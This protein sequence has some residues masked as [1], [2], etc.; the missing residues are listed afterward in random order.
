VRWGVF[1]RASGLGGP[2]RLPEVDTWRG[3]SRPAVGRV[4]GGGSR[5]DSRLRRWRNQVPPTWRIDTRR[6][7]SETHG[8][9]IRDR[10]L[11]ARGIGGVGPI[12]NKKFGVPQEP[13]PDPG[14]WKQ[15]WAQWA[16]VPES[17]TLNTLT[18][19][20]ELE[21]VD[22]LPDSIIGISS[23]GNV[24]LLSQFGKGEPLQAIPSCG[25]RMT[26]L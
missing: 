9:S 13:K 15:E 7:A 25:F 2:R 14:S 1:P 22:N 11:Y 4:A 23:L 3:V 6:R 12:R 10:D 18:E 16:D 17:F 5:D 21:T 8:D 24:G 26:R 20:R 19:E